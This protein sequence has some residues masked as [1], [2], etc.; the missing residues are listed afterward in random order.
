[1]KTKLSIFFLLLFSL[2][3][4]SCKQVYEVELAPAT[5]DI[6]GKP[7]VKINGIPEISDKVLVVTD[8]ASGNIKEFT[9]KRLV[10]SSLKGIKA[11]G[12]KNRGLRIG[13]I[14]DVSE[15]KVGDILVYGSEKDID[16][17]FLIRVVE[18]VTG[19]EGAD[20]LIDYAEAQMNELFKSIEISINLPTINYPTIPLDAKLDMGGLEKIGDVKKSTVIR[21]ESKGSLS[22]SYTPTLAFNIQDYS[23]EKF[24]YLVTERKKTNLNI[25]VGLSRKAEAAL[26]DKTLKGFGISSPPIIIPIGPIPVVIRFKILPY[27]KLKADWTILSL[28]TQVINQESERVFGLSYVKSQPVQLVNKIVSE[29]EEP[30]IYKALSMKGEVSLAGGFDFNM[31]FFSQN[32]FR[33]EEEDYT[34]IGIKAELFGKIS[35]ECNTMNGLKTKISWGGKV[36]FYSK[37]DSPFSSINTEI[38][39]YE[40]P[41]KKV[42]DV[43]LDI[44]FC[45][46]DSIPIAIDQDP[47]IP[48]EVYE[49]GRSFGDPNI[50]T[51]DGR[52]YGFNGAGEFVAVKS[53]TDNFEIQVRQEELK[54]RNTGGS[55]SWNTGL[56]ITTGSDR[57]CFYPNKY[58]I[59]GTQYAYSAN[60]NHTLAGGGNVFGDT[61]TVNVSNNTGDII[62]VFNLTDM[63]NY[64]VI[65]STQRQGKLIGI[66]GDYNKDQANDLK[67]RN[68]TPIDGS[69]ASLYPSYTDSWRIAQAQS[70]FVYDAGKNTNS[71]TDRNFPRSPL[72][73]S[74][75]QRANAEQ[76]CKNAGVVAPYLEGCINDVV[77]TG[78]A[79]SAQWAKALQEETV[80]RSFDIKFGEKEDKSLWKVES[81]VLDGNSLT[82]KPNSSYV[83][84][85]KKVFVR[86]GFESTFYFSGLRSSSGYNKLYFELFPTVISFWEKHADGSNKLYVNANLVD[87]A[88]V[89]DFS[90]SNIDL[91]DGKI[92]KVMIICSRVS[93]SLIK[94]QIIIDGFAA[95]PFERSPTRYYDNLVLERGL[96]TSLA[97]GNYFNSP[98]QTKL[99]RW[100]FKS[101]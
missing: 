34:G 25:A 22:T 87:I 15:I 101:L 74:A 35:S 71:Y 95:L 47:V 41:E 79:N 97:L 66:F 56:A 93:N 100:S 16:K 39:L 24:S 73:I 46:V 51:F 31:S 81:P 49:G 90:K 88:Q 9:A 78:D 53:T 63:L 76:T 11:V 65:P 33:K 84:I 42:H 28:E 45:E 6:Q 7:E 38:P 12:G 99:Y 29:K 13:A 8:E 48:T 86:N 62:K 68:G 96:G 37:F 85:N 55:V 30:L 32:L 5:T 21:V 77:A 10:L 67:L 89:F 94:N 20:I 44:P 98:N 1:M 2:L 82:L 54:N 60:I 3:S 52:P 59:N 69:Y 92:H 61:R 14:T 57:L 36:F 43:T 23:L 4:N 18:V 40:L 83:S 91:F 75:A 58:F 19:I 72:V 70:L 17:S 26:F 64:S 50:V 27:V 80:L